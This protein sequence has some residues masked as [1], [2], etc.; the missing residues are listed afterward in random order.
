M[1]KDLIS[2]STHLLDLGYDRMAHLS[3]AWDHSSA[4]WQNV[5]SE[6]LVR[7]LTILVSENESQES[8]EARLKDLVQQGFIYARPIA[9]TI[10]S[11]KGIQALSHNWLEECLQACVSTAK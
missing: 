11:A 7:T 10:T 3:Y 1:R 2:K 5:F 9:E 4:S 6:T 8:Q